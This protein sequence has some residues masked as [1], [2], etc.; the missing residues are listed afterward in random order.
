MGVYM[1][2][3]VCM[4]RCAGVWLLVWSTTCLSTFVEMRDPLS[5]VLFFHCH[6]VRLGNKRLYPLGHL[7]GPRRHRSPKRPLF[8]STA[9]APERQNP[10]DSVVISQQLLPT[11]VMFDI[12]RVSGNCL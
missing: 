7:T 12:W 11:L 1:G 6:T 9:R 3:C 8:V 10:G 4:V 5:G 2:I